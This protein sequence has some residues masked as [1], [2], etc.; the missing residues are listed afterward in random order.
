MAAATGET[1]PLKCGETST[2]SAPGPGVG[3]EGEHGAEVGPAGRPGRP[4]GRAEPLDDLAGARDVA[5]AVVAARQRRAHVH[6]GAADVG[7]EGVDAA[8]EDG[9][10]PGGVEGLARFGDAGAQRSGG[11]VAAAGA[12]GDAD[13]QAE[14][15]RRLGRQP[16]DDLG[17]GE[18]ARQQP[19]VGPAQRDQVVVPAAGGEVGQAGEVQV[20]GVEERLVPAQPDGAAGDVARRRDHRDRPLA[21]GRLVAL[22]PQQ[23]GPDADGRARSP[24]VRAI[25]SPA[26]AARSATTS[27]Q[28]VSS[29]ESYGVTGRC[30][31]STRPIPAI[32]PATASPTTLAG[33]DPGRRRR[34]AG[35]RRR[36]W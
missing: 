17:A 31:A 36:W 8:A 5:E 29:H 13:G 4:E 23:L 33:V 28:R 30:P 3:G 34:T 25:R 15:L 2:P 12:D 9:G 11:G 6:Q 21:A 27:A 1:R 32:W 7:H 10:G 19:G 24:E 22:P 20:G 35:R 14:R 16:A 18:H 26:R